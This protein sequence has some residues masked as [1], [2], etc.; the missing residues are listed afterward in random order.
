MDIIGKEEKLVE[1]IRKNINLLP[2]L[3]RFGIR[4]GFRDKSVEDLCRETAINQEFFLAIINTFNN[5]NYFPEDEFLTFSALE[6]V[7]YLKKTHRYYLNYIL[8]K[9][10]TLLEQL[11]D[12]CNDGCQDLKMIELFYKNYK[13]ELILHIKEEEELVFPYISQLVKAPES[14][15]SHPGIHAF[16]KEHSN[17]EIKL[18]DLK[19]LIIKYVN[20][21]YDI[22]ICNEFL[23]TLFAFEQDIL[24]H[25]R[26]EDKILI[27]MV[28]KMENGV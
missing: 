12:D 23:I 16:E 24:D 20:Q 13:Q 4:L 21:D 2:V 28:L 11:L 10:D 14:I 6:I 15:T 27:P 18:N 17:V 26:I 19:N 3:D 22:N 8:P 9:L 25:A 5:K 7:E 1:I